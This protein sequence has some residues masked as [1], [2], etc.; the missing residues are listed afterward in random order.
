MEKLAKESLWGKI[1]KF[2]AQLSD[3]IDKKME[4]EAKSSP[5]C[6]KPAEGK[7]KTCCS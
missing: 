4:A 1:R 2:F 7:D 3:N 5:C 6:C